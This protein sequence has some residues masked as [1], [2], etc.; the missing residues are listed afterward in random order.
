MITDFF[1][2]FFVLS[3]VFYTNDTFLQPVFLRCF[4]IIG[5]IW[6]WKVIIGIFPV[7]TV[8]ILSWLTYFLWIILDEEVWRRTPSWLD[9][10]MSEKVGYTIL[11]LLVT[12]IGIVI[13][14]CVGFLVLEI[15]CFTAFAFIVWKYCTNRWLHYSHFLVNHRVNAMIDFMAKSKDKDDEMLRILAI[16]YETA[17]LYAKKPGALN[18]MIDK[19]YSNQGIEG[20]KLFYIH[21]LLMKFFAEWLFFRF[22]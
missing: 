2:I 1:G 8:G 19:I 12:P 17:K 10:T 7:I 11:L 20:L 16:N 6:C 9:R 14:S 22:K 18:I 3:W 13:G 5:E 15:V 21:F 4:S